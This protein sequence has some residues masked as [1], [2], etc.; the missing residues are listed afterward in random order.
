M[1]KRLAMIG[2]LLAALCLTSCSHP[3]GQA[4]N[5]LVRNSDF[6]VRLVTDSPLHTGAA[7]LTLLITHHNTNTPAHL[8]Q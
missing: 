7:T 3:Q 2:L 4:M 1:T 6:D 5:T 8:D